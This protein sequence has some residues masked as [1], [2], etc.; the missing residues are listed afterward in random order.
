MGCGPAAASGAS[1]GRQ[2]IVKDSDS[3]QAHAKPLNGRGKSPFA[4][5]FRTRLLT[6]F[7]T[8]F[9]FCAPRTSCVNHFEGASP[10]LGANVA[11]VW[12][13]V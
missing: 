3:R 13:G 12:T 4:A 11:P 1:Q 2:I 9:A 10:S 7:F 5:D 8:F 6:G